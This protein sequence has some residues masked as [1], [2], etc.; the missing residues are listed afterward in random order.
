MRPHSNPIRWS[1]KVSPLVTLAVAQDAG[2]LPRPKMIDR[3]V[4]GPYRHLRCRTGSITLSHD[5]HVSFGAAINFPNHLGNPDWYHVRGYVAAPYGAFVPRVFVGTSTSSTISAN[6][7]AAA[8][9]PLN[10]YMLLPPV[11]ISNDQ[12]SAYDCVISL[13]STDFDAADK[14]LV[15]GVQFLN[16]N[17]SAVSARCHS[18]IMVR[19]MTEQ[20]GK[21][22][23]Y[24][25]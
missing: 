15:F 25:T 18:D 22:D 17:L 10:D 11:S 19:H 23:P 13:Q 5:Q 12:G 14:L 9:L 2:A 21:N 16:S 8:G 6:A 4:A 20:E 24:L 3:V 1:F 7:A